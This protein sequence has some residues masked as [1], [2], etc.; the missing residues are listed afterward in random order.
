VSPLTHALTLAVSLAPS[1]VEYERLARRCAF[2]WQHAIAGDV[3]SAARNA[4]TPLALDACATED[5]ARRA[6]TSTLTHLRDVR[7]QG[8]AR[9]LDTQIA[10]LAGVAVQLWLSHREDVGSRETLV[11][12]PIDDEHVEEPEETDPFWRALPKWARNAKPISSEE[13]DAEYEREHSAWRLG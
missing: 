3:L 4:C 8:F 11:P 6:F 2:V 10:F 12:P 5:D 1:S 13:P 9:L 7:E